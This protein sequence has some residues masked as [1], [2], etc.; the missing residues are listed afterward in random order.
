MSM[1]AH[2]SDAPGSAPAWAALVALVR[3]ITG[4]VAPLGSGSQPIPIDLR[5][6][7]R[8]AL[9]AAEGRLRRLLESEAVALIPHLPARRMRA[10]RA[11]GHGLANAL[12][13]GTAAACDTLSPET[14]PLPAPRPD[15]RPAPDARPEPDP[16]SGFR[17]HETIG[18]VSPV[19]RFS[20]RFRPTE[21]LDP[22]GLDGVPAR[23]EFLRYC[24]LVTT[25]EF[26]GP[27][28][29]RLALILRRRA[30]QAGE[31]VAPG[32][33]GPP[34]HG[35]DSFG[36]GD[37]LEPGE[38]VLPVPWRRDWAPPSGLDLS[39]PEPAIGPCRSG[40]PGGP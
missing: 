38:G 12:A 23:A 31:G 5:R 1:P 15:F 21:P 39:P 36:P 27:T 28:V 34:G 40:P 10:C 26:P 4:L 33:G 7:I 8:L 29:R 11:S 3:A 20:D 24:R 14:G 32:E 22:Y 16:F 30:D 35:P 9:R 25:V 2:P 18:P 13:N 19:R 17:L 6:R 37:R